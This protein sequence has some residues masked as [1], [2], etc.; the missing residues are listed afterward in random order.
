MGLVVVGC[1]QAEA[2]PAWDAGNLL[3]LRSR[4]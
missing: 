2:H 1:R 4:K 3:G